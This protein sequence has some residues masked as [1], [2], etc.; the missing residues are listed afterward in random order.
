MAQRKTANILEVVENQER[1]WFALSTFLLCCLVMLAD[2]FDNQA[3]NYAAPYIIKEWGIERALMTPVFNI[4]IVGWM[5]GSI[6]FAMLADRIGR[7][8]ATLLAALLFGGF[9]LAIPLATNLVEL[10]MLRF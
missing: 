7:R 1:N 2:G 8:P 9:T 6:V 5:S 3:I 10:S 4:S